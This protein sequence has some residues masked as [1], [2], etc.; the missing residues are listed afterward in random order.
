MGPSIRVPHPPCPFPFLFLLQSKPRP[1]MASPGD[2]GR[3]SPASTQAKSRRLAQGFLDPLFHLARPG[4]QRP[5]LSPSASSPLE[6][7]S[8]GSAQPT[9]LLRLGARGPLPGSDRQKLGKPR[10]RL[11]LLQPPGIAEAPRNPW[12]TWKGVGSRPKLQPP[13][14]YGNAEKTNF[15]R[16][17]AA[18][19]EYALQVSFFCPRSV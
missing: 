4:C 9:T 18:R 1:G 3:R 11:F 5:S 17:A 16:P 6:A 7:S 14:S 10:D 2:L 19:C 15:L 8:S 13:R 12:L